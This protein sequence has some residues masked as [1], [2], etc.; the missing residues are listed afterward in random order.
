MMQ[1]VSPL[2]ER[3]LLINADWV[4]RNQRL[5]LMKVL[6]TS[7]LGHTYS[8]R[9]MVVRDI[10]YRC[11]QICH[12]VHAL[13]LLK[14]KDGARNDHSRHDCS[15]D[16]LSI[17]V[18][19]RTRYPRGHVGGLQKNQSDFQALPIYTPISSSRHA[20]PNLGAGMLKCG[21][22]RS[23]RLKVQMSVGVRLDPM[24]GKRHL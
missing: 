17:A 5:E 6:C 10:W 3:P 4:H 13:R 24:G 15:G 8:S 16:Q 9:T 23:M 12:P 14:T 2:R 20:V 11:F 22:A 21:D 19:G 18:L 7:P 1:G